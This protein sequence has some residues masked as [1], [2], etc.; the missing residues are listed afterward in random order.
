MSAPSQPEAGRWP[1][2]GVVLAGGVSRRMGRSK[3]DLKLPDGRTMIDAVVG[4]LRDVCA[5]VVVAGGVDIGLPRVV[6]LRSDQG[7]LGG[8]EAVLAS[9]VDEQYLVCPCDVPLVTGDL[10]RALLAAPPVKAA[11]F[12]VEGEDGFRPLPARIPADRRGPAAAM[13]DRQQ[14]S[15]RD[16]LIA[17]GVEVVSL[18]RAAGARLANVNTPA[19]YEAL[20]KASLS[21]DR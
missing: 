20:C 21:D 11:V 1:H 14:R 6:D 13:L 15:V 7:P 4:A 16:F 9:G 2:T 17:T 8:I 12:G 10:L 19:D 5:R 18:S 3:H